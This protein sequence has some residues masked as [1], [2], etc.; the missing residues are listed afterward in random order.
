MGFPL[1]AIEEGPPL[2]P[3]PMK[4]A[5]RICYPISSFL[6]ALPAWK[7]LHGIQQTSKAAA[8]SMNP[9]SFVSRVPGLQ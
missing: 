7:A 8:A 5:S 1:T 9:L 2:N 4:A 3:L 6:A